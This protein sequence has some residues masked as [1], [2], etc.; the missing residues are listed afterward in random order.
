M[1]SGPRFLA[2]RMSRSTAS[3]PPSRPVRSN[4]SRSVLSPPRLASSLADS[5]VPRLPRYSV[6]DSTSALSGLRTA[7][8]W[9][10]EMLGGS[11]TPNRLALTYCASYL[12]TLPV[13]ERTFCAHDIQRSR[14]PSMPSHPLVG[15][16]G[17]LSRHQ[18]ST[19]HI[20][21]PGVGGGIGGGPRY[22]SQ[23]LDRITALPKMDPF[24]KRPANP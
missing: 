3:S 6:I 18:L 13:V 12:D 22:G 11:M 15:S 23:E 9:P 24:R 4:S 2:N 5:R 14:R 19:C 17:S 8:D 1:A 20:T 16:V 7:T 21:D 10:Q